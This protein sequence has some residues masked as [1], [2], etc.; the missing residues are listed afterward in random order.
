MNSW[1]GGEFNLWTPESIG[2]WAH[3]NEEFTGNTETGLRFIH[4][5]VFPTVKELPPTEKACTAMELLAEFPDSKWIFTGDMH[6]AFHFE[7]KGRHVMLS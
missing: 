6:T 7:H 1:S 3:F 5:L 2:M 4:R